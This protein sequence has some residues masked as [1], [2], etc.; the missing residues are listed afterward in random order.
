MKNNFAFFIA[1]VLCLQSCS[2]PLT[3]GY[4]FIDQ[5]KYTEAADFF[6]ANLH[7][8]KFKYDAFLGR[9]IAYNLSGKNS[10]AVIDYDSCIRINPKSDYA[11]CNKSISLTEMGKPDDALDE[12]NLALQRYSLSSLGSYQRAKLFVY[13]KNYEGSLE[14]LDIAIR[15]W[16][17]KSNECNESCPL[18]LRALIY[19]K[20][21]EYAKA[22]ADYTRAGRKIKNFV[23]LN[24]NQGLC[25]LQKQDTVAAKLAFERAK[26]L[27]TKKTIAG[28]FAQVQLAKL[29]GEIISV[30]EL[31]EKL[32][33]SNTSPL[34]SNYYLACLHSINGNHEKAIE[35]LSKCMKENRNGFATMLLDYQLAAT[36]QKYNL[37]RLVVS[38]GEDVV[39]I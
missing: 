26:T 36:A 20:K 3:Q 10:L 1:A 19:Q 33:A 37:Y 38:G 23:L 22:L 9:G 35:Y 6:S 7:H 11:Y 15:L 25:Y 32:K 13:F 28:L 34:Q 24:Y 14:D 12:I 16:N 2:Y 18:T 8:K 4:K 17:S 39:K 31:E 21:E 29:R 30:N 5:K 27:D